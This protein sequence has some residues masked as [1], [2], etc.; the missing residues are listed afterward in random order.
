MK[1]LI[2]GAAVALG[3]AC[4][5]VNGYLRGFTQCGLDIGNNWPLPHDM[6]CPL[7]EHQ[8]GFVKIGIGKDKVKD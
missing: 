1:K 4:V 3:T 7:I 2:C 8:L 6:E 5:W